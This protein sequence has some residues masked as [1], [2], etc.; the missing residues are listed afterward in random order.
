MKPD[1]ILDVSRIR[2]LGVVLLRE[3]S[4]KLFWLTSE[5]L[6][7]VD[8]MESLLN[9]GY[10]SVHRRLGFDNEMFTPKSADY[11]KQ[12]DDIIE[13]IRNF[14]GEKNEKNWKEKTVPATPWSV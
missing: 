7:V 3:L 2:A 14:Y 8:L 5:T 11:M 6:K 1:L 13:Q 12:K 4:Q 10:S 9:G